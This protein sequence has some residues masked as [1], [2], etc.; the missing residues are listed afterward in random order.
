MKSL[1]RFFDR[2]RASVRSS[3]FSGRRSGRTWSWT[4]FTSLHTRR[5]RYFVG[6]TPG[7]RAHRIRTTALDL[8]KRSTVRPRHWRRQDHA[9]RLGH[10]PRISRQRVVENHGRF[11]C[12]PRL[13]RL[14]QVRGYRVDGERLR[15]GRRSHRQLAGSPGG[16]GS[17][18]GPPVWTVSRWALSFSNI[19][20]QSWRPSNLGL[21]PKNAALRSRDR[22]EPAARC[23]P[24]TARESPGHVMRLRGWPDLLVQRAALATSAFLQ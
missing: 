6:S 10:P 24:P 21:S 17:A 2:A 4:R 14:G 7:T 5:R 11:L 22:V 1:A 23:S 19:S 18:S 15:P 13:S 16:D 9:R 20:G 8:Y 3:S 12:P